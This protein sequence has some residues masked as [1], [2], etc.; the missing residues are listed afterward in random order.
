MQKLL[1]R[2]PEDLKSWIETRSIRNFRAMNSEVV[3]ILSP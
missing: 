1:V 3:A 2:L